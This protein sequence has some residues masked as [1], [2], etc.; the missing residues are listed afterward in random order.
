MSDAALPAQGPVDV[1]VRPVVEAYKDWTGVNDDRWDSLTDNQLGHSAAYPGYPDFR[2]GWDAAI[3]L[4]SAEVERLTWAL[5]HGGNKYR[6]PA[7]VDKLLP[8]IQRMRA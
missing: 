8:M 5:D 1:D 2:A 3:A 6:R 7:E 4:L